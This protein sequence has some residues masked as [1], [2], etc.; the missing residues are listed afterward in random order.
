LRIVLFAL[1][2]ADYSLLYVD[3]GCQGR[4]SNGGVF[5]NT[6]LKKEEVKSLKI[7][8]PTI[9]QVPYAV[10]LPYYILGDRAFALNE[11]TLKPFEENPDR[12][13][14]ERVFNYRISR[15]RRVGENAFGILSSDFRVLRKPKLL[16]PDKATKLLWLLCTYV[17]F[18]QKKQDH[19]HVAL[20]EVVSITCALHSRK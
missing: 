13:S 4:I 16:E 5:K 9:L 14:I 12:G 6:Q 8:P 15:A 11:Y 20:P 3:V 1:V 17:T 18:S 10:E 19:V 2:D 7:P